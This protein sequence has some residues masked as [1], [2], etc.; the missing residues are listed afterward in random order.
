MSNEPSCVTCR[1]SHSPDSVLPLYLG[2]KLTCSICLEDVPSENCWVLPCGHSNCKECLGIIGFIDKPLS[3]PTPTPTSPEAVEPMSQTN[4]NDTT[5]GLRID[6]RRI[7][8]NSVI[9]WDWDYI[10]T[11][12]DNPW[13]YIPRITNI[14]NI[15]IKDI[16]DT[17]D[18]PWNWYYIYGKPNITLND[19]TLNDIEYDNL[20]LNDIKNYIHSESERKRRE[21]DRHRRMKQA[22]R[23][24]LKDRKRRYMITNHRKR[25]QKKRYSGRY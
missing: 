9:P 10:D 24:K 20:T 7:D 6:W 12:P 15:T 21:K 22:E 16:I 25:H 3:T 5:V 23:L 11:N 18:K 14:P 13:Y 8:N 17:C 19:I 2:V 4:F 1:T